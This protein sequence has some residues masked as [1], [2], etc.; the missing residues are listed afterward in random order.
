MKRQLL[1]LLLFLSIFFIF[2]TPCTN[3]Q[4]WE[5]NYT[6][7]MLQGFYW[8]SFTDTRW[9]KLEKQADE[10]ANYFDLV[11]IPQSACCS[12]ASCRKV[13][14]DRRKNSEK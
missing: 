9:T 7:V 8:D 4:G 11:W 5:E 2:H 6:G 12:I 10:L 3:A 1:N 14:S 13:R